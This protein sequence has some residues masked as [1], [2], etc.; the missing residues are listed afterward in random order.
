MGAIEQK[1][2]KL[3]NGETFG[4]RER[5]GIGEKIL[6]VHGNMTSSKHWDL[7]MENIDPSFHLIAVDMRGFGESSYHEKFYSIQELA[8]DIKLFVDELDL[9]DFCLV[10]WSTGGAVG[11]QFA[12][13]NPGYCNKLILLASASTRGYPIF[14]TDESGQQ[15]FSKRLTSFDQVMADKTRTIPITQAYKSKDKDML[16]MIW[17]YAIYH[18]NRP[19]EDRYQ[20][21]LEDMMTQR[22]YPEILH[23]LNTF[24]ISEKNNGLKDGTGEVNNINIPVLVLAGEKDLVI[25]EQM[26]GEILEDLGDKASFIQ[27]KGCGHSAL[28]DDLPQLL[29]AITTF[30]KTQEEQYQ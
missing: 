24:N 16:R 28:V 11:M 8:D 23:A 27:L 29:E 1:T 5:E 12:A 3:A 26:T 22:N 4:Y 30:V 7:V 19:E 9:S 2:V 20:E 25:T 14:D 10:G 21:Y 18:D 17:D 13:D 6:L 15:D